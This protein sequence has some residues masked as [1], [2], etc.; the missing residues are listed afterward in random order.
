MIH[1]F[2]FAKKELIH[3]HNYCDKIGFKRAFGV[4]R[5]MGESVSR[6]NLSEYEYIRSAIF[7]KDNAKIAEVKKV[8]SAMNIWDNVLVYYMLQLQPKDFLDTQDYW[9][10]KV[11]EGTLTKPIGK[12]VSVA[13]TDNNHLNIEDKSY[14]VPQ[15]HAIEFSPM[16]IHDIPPVKNKETWAVFMV[17]NYVNVT[18][19][20]INR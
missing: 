7:Y 12:F 5:R 17:G 10:K 9:I 3:F 11:K 19:K 14:V 8:T 13:L 4:G 15:F 16:K 20:I 1:D 18:E 6:N 2:T